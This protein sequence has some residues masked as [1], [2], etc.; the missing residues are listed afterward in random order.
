MKKEN[1][2]K[3][4]KKPDEDLIIG[5][6][7]NLTGIKEKVNLPDY[8]INKKIQKKYLKEMPFNKIERKTYIKNN[9][10]TSSKDK[11]EN[12]KE[13]IYPSGI[14]KKINKDEK[15]EII[16]ETVDYSKIRE[17]YF[18]DFKQNLEKELEIL[19]NNAFLLYNRGKIIRN[20]VKK[21]L[22]TKVLEEKILIWKYYIKD[23]SKEEI[24]HLIRKLLYYIDKFSKVCYE[25]FL[26]INEVSNAY[27]LLSLNETIN[28]DKNNNNLFQRF[29]S[30]NSMVGVD[31]EGNPEEKKLS[32]LDEANTM[33]LLSTN[34]LNI[35]NELNGTGYAYVFLKEL[36]DIGNMY[37][38]SSIIFESIFH[39]CF[40]IFKDKN[41]IFKDFEI[42]RLLLGYFSDYFIDN[43][44]TLKFFMKLQLLFGVYKQYD[45][46]KFINRLVLARYNS[47][48][49]LENVKKEII[50]LIGPEEELDEEKK[51]EKMENIDDIVKYIEE[52]NKVKKK[53]KKKKNKNKINQVDEL[54]NKK[55][56]ENI[57]K[58]NVD[59]D[60]DDYDDRISIIS[61]E[62]SVLENFK[63]DII[64]ETEFNSGSKIIPI[65]S[66]GFVNKLK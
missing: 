39:N 44:F 22:S 1:T 16:E 56:D 28:D 15:N 52:D 20:I 9:K 32:F 3:E 11:N 55:E 27:L 12:M 57:N 62:D 60:M 4:D 53:K 59:N 8:K 17:V 51:I 13:I 54:F 40:L 63:N 61:E 58:I 31:E 64:A 36:K 29:F 43:C 23:L 42:F 66:L 7:R 18:N 2:K 37:F 21:P 33:M 47:F 48:D 5:C 45:V 10:N 46:L 6:I 50:N 35:K 30:M 41:Y 49:I 65:L 24:S 14:I 34:I 38:Y 25:E 26:K 19:I